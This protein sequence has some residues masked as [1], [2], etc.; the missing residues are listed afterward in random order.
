MGCRWCRSRRLLS[1]SAL[2]ESREGGGT[3]HPRRAPGSTRKGTRTTD[4]TDTLSP[5]PGAHHDVHHA[6][7]AAAGRHRQRDAPR[8]P[9]GARRRL[10]GVGHLRPVRPQSQSRRGE[11]AVRHR[12][13][14]RP[15][16]LALRVQHLHADRRPQRRPRQPP[17]R[18]PD[19]GRQ[20]VPPAQATPCGPAEADVLV[21]ATARQVEPRP[22]PRGVACGPHRSCF[23]C[24]SEGSRR[25]LR[26][27]SAC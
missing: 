15:P 3:R 13:P 20:P 18:P 12:R 8:R 26:K 1:L 9:A 17:G 14:P 6:L 24:R 2:D 10:P 4:T 21:V 27:R 23:R 19:R 7:A 22:H 16:R 25:G 5:P 11:R